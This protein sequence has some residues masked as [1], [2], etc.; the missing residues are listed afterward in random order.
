M[1]AEVILYTDGSAKGNPGPGG[2]AALLHH[3]RSGQRKAIAGGYRRTT[4]NRMEL[5]AVIEGLQLLNRAP[6]KVLVVSDSKYVVDAVAKGWVF[7]WERTGFKG[8]K[9]EDLWRLFLGVYRR[10]EVRFEWI[11]G[12]AQHPENEYCDQLAQKAATAA[13]LD[14]DRGFEALSASGLF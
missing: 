2:W 7:N 12:H 5:W 1:Q 11:K 13:N 4:N 9:N 3:V 6:V 10:H 8:K 14:V